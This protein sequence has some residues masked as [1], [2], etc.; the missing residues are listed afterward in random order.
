M[1]AA[2]VVQKFAA[3]HTLFD[4]KNLMQDMRVWCF[5]WGFY[6]LGSALDLLG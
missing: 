4:A 5:P 6:V 2:L 3:R 1:V